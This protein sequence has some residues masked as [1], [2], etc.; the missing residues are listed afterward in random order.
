MKEGVIDSKGVLVA[1]HMIGGSG[2]DERIIVVSREPAACRHSV[3]VVSRFVRR[4]GSRG[5]GLFPVFLFS[6]FIDGLL[7]VAIVTVV[8]LV[9]TIPTLDIRIRGA[10]RPLIVVPGGLEAFVKLPALLRDGECPRSRHCG[11]LICLYISKRLLDG[12]PG[13]GPAICEVSNLGS[14]R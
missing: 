10:A 2:V 7:E 8:T 13:S 12:R 6:E 3:G 5:G 4:G 1:T 9:G 11:G 14:P